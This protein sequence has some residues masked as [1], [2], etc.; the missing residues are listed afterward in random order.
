MHHSHV[1]PLC[2]IGL[3]A[4]FPATQLPHHESVQKF[5][6]FFGIQLPAVCISDHANFTTAAFVQREE[7]L[8][9]VASSQRRHLIMK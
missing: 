5:C 3:T 6:L 1:T 7:K 4:F 9:A 8:L 2:S